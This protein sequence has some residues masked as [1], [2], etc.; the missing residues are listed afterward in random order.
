MTSP[1]KPI[2]CDFYD[3]L[4]AL[5]VM[6]RKVEIV[7]RSEAGNPLTVQAVINNLYVVEH[8]EYMLLD[9]N[10]VIRLD[11]LISVDGKMLAHYC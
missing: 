1:Y 10:Q 9:N 5:A 3:E 6:H 11:A 4:E 7:Y 2:S 8:V